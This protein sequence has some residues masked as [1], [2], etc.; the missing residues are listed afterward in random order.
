MSIYEFLSDE[1]KIVIGYFPIDPTKPST[2]SGNM[3]DRMHV[4]SHSE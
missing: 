3:A 1:L 2:R 4:A